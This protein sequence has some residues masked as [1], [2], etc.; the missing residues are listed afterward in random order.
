MSRLAA[1]KKFYRLDE[2]EARL[3]I[4]FG[5]AVTVSDIL[6][7]L[8]DERLQLSALF[9]HQPAFVVAPVTNVYN[10][11]GGGDSDPTALPPLAR[12]P[13]DQRVISEGVTRQLDFVT[14]L[15]G[16]YRLNMHGPLV[17]SYVQHLL[18]NTEF[19]EFPL[20]STEGVQVIGDDDTLYELCVPFNWSKSE[21]KQRNAHREAINLPPLPKRPLHHVDNYYPSPDLPPLRQLV[22][23]TQ[24]LLSFEFSVLNSEKQTHSDEFELN[25][26]RK[27]S[28]LRLLLGMA[29]D[30]YGYDTKAATSPTAREISESVSALGPEFAIDSDTVRTYLAEASGKPKRRYGKEPKS[31]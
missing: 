14:H 21:I 6:Q 17:A 7:F 1:L 11:Y 20:T 13:S 10:W 3:S 30:G 8:V 28:M 27:N 5:E 29:I 18:M 24:D 4:A 16:V 25:A 15:D 23:R 9:L 22:L 12:F 31:V 19:D 26:K 2:A